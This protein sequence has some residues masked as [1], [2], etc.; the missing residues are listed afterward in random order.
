[1][2]RHPDPFLH[3][4]CRAAYWFHQQSGGKEEKQAG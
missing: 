2:V 3:F 1:M 4:L